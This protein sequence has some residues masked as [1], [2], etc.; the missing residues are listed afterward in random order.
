MKSAHLVILE[1]P[2]F[3]TSGPFL[4]AIHP[5]TLAAPAGLLEAGHLW[6]TM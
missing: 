6:R 3:T 2:C 5:P 4:S 1:R